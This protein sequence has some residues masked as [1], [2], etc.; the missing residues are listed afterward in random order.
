MFSKVLI[1]NR[2]EI[3]LRIQR[4]CREMGIRTVA[5]HSTADAAAMQWTAYLRGESGRLVYVAFAARLF[6]PDADGRPFAGVNVVV[7]DGGEKLIDRWRR[8]PP[9]AA[10]VAPGGRRVTIGESELALD[11]STDPPRFRL[12]A[13]A[14]EGARRVEVS[15][16]L[17]WEIGDCRPAGFTLLSD[18][19]RGH[20]MEYA[21]PVLD[22]P[23]LGRLE[24]GGATERVDGRG[25]LESIRWLRSPMVRPARWYWGFATGVPGA[26]LVFH[27][28]YPGAQSLVLEGRGAGCAT[29]VEDAALE[30]R[31]AGD[32]VIVERRA[33]AD[34][35]E[36]AVE[37]RRRPADPFPIFLA[38]YTLD[39]KESETSRGEMVFEVGEWR[40]F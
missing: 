28:D 17:A 1:A 40:S 8:V 22:G 33:G 39:R 38:P 25:Y 18:R 10:R 37:D 27:P 11:D 16:T 4:A 26:L 24:A 7:L 12:R 23:F 30:V 21:V 9:Q 13:V 19:E 31:R 5:V 15:G 2:G 3:A 36:L 35:F 20:H 29:A 14:G 6:P 34:G 32:R